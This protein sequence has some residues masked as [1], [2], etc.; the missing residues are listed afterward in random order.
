MIE[1]MALAAHA[2]R[3]SQDPRTAVG[4]VVHHPER[5]VLA[6]AA[7]RLPPGLADTDPTRLAAPAKYLWIEH[8]ERAALMLAARDGIATVGAAAFVHGGFPCADCA[9]AIIAAGLVEVAFSLARSQVAHWEDSY[10]ASRAMLTEAGVRVTE[11]AQA[12]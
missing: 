5:G 8:A 4:C 7:N 3:D 10:R 2:A 1:M 9:R 12:I 11:V 6:V